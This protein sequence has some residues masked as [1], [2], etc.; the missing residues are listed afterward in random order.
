MGLGYESEMCTTPQHIKSYPF[1][2]ENIVKI[3]GGGGGHVMV[4]TKSREIYACGWNH[5]GQLGINNTQNSFHFVKVPLD[6]VEIVDI[7]CGWDSSAA[8]DQNG[9]LYLWGSNAFNQLGLCAKTMPFTTKP[10]PVELPWL[11]KAKKISFGLRYLC[12]L[13]EDNDV[14]F[15]GRF[16]FFS[17]YTSM[18]FKDAEF[19][20]L[21]D[22]A[23]PLIDHLSSGSNHIVYASNLSRTV[24]GYGD[25]KFNQINCIELKSEIKCLRSGWAHNGALTED[26]HVFLWGRNT[27]GQ[28]ASDNTTNTDLVQLNCNDHIED[29]QLGSEHGCALTRKGDV[30]TWGWNEHGNCGNG[31]EQNVYVNLF[32]IYLFSL[33]C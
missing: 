19:W 5:R 30:L 2:V 33:N 8:I 6:D 1:D 24:N 3:E 12:I 18:M 32:L 7:A 20:E 31:N 23:L 9:Q 29:F 15:L 26:G 25:N 4:L 21:N 11:Q 14:Y 10:V 13:C 22:I 27:Y 17:G 28:L 16:K